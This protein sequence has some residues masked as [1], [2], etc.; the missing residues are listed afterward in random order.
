MYR[1]RLGSLP[2]VIVSLY[3][4]IILNACYSSIDG[5]FSALSSIVAVDLVKP[6]VP[7]IAEKRLFALTKSSMPPTVKS[8]SG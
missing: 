7:D 6:L 1:H 4:L 5:A 2:V 3:V 8:I